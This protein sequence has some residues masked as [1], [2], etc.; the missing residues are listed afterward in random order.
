MRLKQYLEEKR[1]LKTNLEGMSD[2]ELLKFYNKH[3]KKNFS[4][5][6]GILF[7]SL[8]DLIKTRKLVIDL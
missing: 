2:N 1:N 3:K 8:M 6:S 5:I 4:N 7:T